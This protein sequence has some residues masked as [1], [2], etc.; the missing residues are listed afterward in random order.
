MIQEVLQPVTIQEAVEMKKQQPGATGYFAGGTWINHAGSKLSYNT[1]ITIS[2]LG[3]DTIHIDGE[4]LVIGS[5]VTLQSLIDSEMTPQVLKDSAR[6]IYSR[7]VRNMA[8]I[9][10]NI[11]AR[12]RES[13]LIPLLIA[14]E[15]T[16]EIAEAGIVSI[17]EYLTTSGDGLITA[18]RIPVLK[19]RVCAKRMV[20]SSS[21]SALV[22]IAVSVLNTHDDHE[23]CPLVALNGLKTCVTQVPALNAS[24]QKNWNTTRTEK[25]AEVKDLLTREAAIEADIRCSSEYKF[26]IAA[27]LICDCVQELQEVAL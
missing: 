12:Q 16:L 17:S 7:N 27:E 5:C 11:A 18:V 6:Y 25:I 2:Q 13:A 19:R 26:L 10:G 22:S 1:V 9:G 23:L 15:A 21:S 3:L 8:T 24:I 20:W 4:Y 14:Y